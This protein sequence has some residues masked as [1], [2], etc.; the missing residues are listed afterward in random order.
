MA[1]SLWPELYDL[2]HRTQ[3]PYQ[4]TRADVEELNYDVFPHWL[5]NILLEL[6]QATYSRQGSPGENGQAVIFQLLHHLVFFPASKPN[7]ISHTIP[8]FSGAVK[9][10]LRRIIDQAWEKLGTVTDDSQKTL[11]SAVAEAMGA[12]SP[13]RADW[14]TVPTSWRRVRQTNSEEA[15]S[16]SW[17][18]FTA[19][20][21]NI[22]LRPSVRG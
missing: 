17:P 22:L 19:M 1:L 18:E 14:R 10:G 11:Y 8:D 6:A 4:I 20:S 5:D 13:T 12:L 2:P 15:N 7:C 16:W 3:N 21:R 9:Q